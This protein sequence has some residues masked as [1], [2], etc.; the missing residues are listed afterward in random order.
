MIRIINL[1]SFKSLMVVLISMAFLNTLGNVLFVVS[2]DS[3]FHCWISDYKKYFLTLTHNRFLPSGFSLHFW[4]TKIKSFDFDEFINLTLTL[5]VIT[6]CSVKT[7]CIIEEILT[8]FWY[9]IIFLC[10]CFFWKS[11]LRSLCHILLLCPL[12]PQRVLLV[13]L[14][15][16]LS[17]S[18]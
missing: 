15:P 2:M 13:V 5:S 10:M 9:I 11:V 14:H 18:Q 12:L 3:L 8:S 17:P 6:Q 7:P 1:S 16:K 4:S